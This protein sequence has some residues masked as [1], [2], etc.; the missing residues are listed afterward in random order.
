MSVHNEIHTDRTG[1]TVDGSVARPV[2]DFS[3]RDLGTRLRVVCVHECKVN[4]SLSPMWRT[5]A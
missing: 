2:L 4:W 3:G 5:L 1:Q